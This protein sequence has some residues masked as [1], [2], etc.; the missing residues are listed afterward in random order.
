MDN[1]CVGL[2]LYQGDKLIGVIPNDNFSVPVSIG[3]E[4]KGKRWRMKKRAEALSWR[5]MPKSF[6][7]TIKL[8]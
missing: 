6:S 7:C 8:N 1:N 3:Y 5:R 4:G 2:Y